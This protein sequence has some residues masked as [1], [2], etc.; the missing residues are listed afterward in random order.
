MEAVQVSYGDRAQLT[1][2][3]TGAKQF[4][5]HEGK[6]YRCPPFGSS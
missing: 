4:D 2:V 6:E 5:L 3:G 1:V